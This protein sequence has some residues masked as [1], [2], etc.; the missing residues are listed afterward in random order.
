MTTQD[1]LTI[2]ERR[3]G[4]QHARKRLEIERDHEAQV[5]GPGINFFHFENLRL[6]QLAIRAVLTVTGLYGRG[7]RNAAKVVIRENRIES[8]HLP[9]IFDAFTILQLS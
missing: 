5:F 8:P 9:E 1:I 2:L 4:A 6:S 3:L 7:I